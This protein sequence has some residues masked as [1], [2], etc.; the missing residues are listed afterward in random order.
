MS[1]EDDVIYVSEGLLHE[2]SQEKFSV[3]IKKKKDQ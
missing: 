1:L 3:S 2:K